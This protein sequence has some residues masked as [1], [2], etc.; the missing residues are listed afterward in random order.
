MITDAEINGSIARYRARLE[1]QARYA[2]FDYCF[3]YFRSFHDRDDVSGL[4]AKNQLQVSCLQLGF[5]LASWGMLRGSS[6][7]LQRSVRNFIPVVEAIADMPEEVWSIDVDSY[8]S[9]NCDALLEGVARIRRSFPERA[10]DILVTKTM[11]GVFGG[12]PAFDQFFKKGF[13]AHTV[14]G[15]SLRKVGQFYEDHTEVIDTNRV[16]TISFD[17]GA[18]TDLMYPRAKVIDMVFFTVGGGS[19]RPR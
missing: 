15:R 14:S 5:Y 4:A 18:A 7:L 12:M 9:T 1:P 8:S 10:S 6:V 2:S 11:L 3:N 19:A 13:S 16:P 17:T